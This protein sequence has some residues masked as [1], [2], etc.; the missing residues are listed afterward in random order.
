[1]TIRFDQLPS[2]RPGFTVPKGQYAALIE[3]AEMKTS[4]TDPSKPAYLNL[5]LAISDESGKGMGKVYDILTESDNEYVR[6]KLKR[7]IEAMEIP[8]TGSIELKDIAKIVS[9]KRTRVDIMMDEKS[10]SPR[11]VVD[12]FSAEIYYP[13]TQPLDAPI[14]ASDATDSEDPDD[15][16]FV[17]DTPSTQY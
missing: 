1:M 7:F 17:A 14:N 4:K 11:P 16:P 5:T 3:K 13:L 6:Y 8:M 2:E 12:I 9:G 10:T 15:N